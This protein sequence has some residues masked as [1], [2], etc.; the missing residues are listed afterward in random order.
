MQTWWLWTLLSPHWISLTLG[1]FFTLMCALPASKCLQ[2]WTQEFSKND[3]TY[4]ST[5]YQL[6]LWKSKYFCLKQINP[7]PLKTSHSF[8]SQVAH[9]LSA[10]M[11][12]SLK[13]FK[14]YRSSFNKSL[15]QVSRLSTTQRFYTTGNTFQHVSIASL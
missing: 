12:K 1:E 14:C 3:Y 4:L 10:W 15:G 6:L 13:A 5:I 2:D 7:T 9:T 11:M 8:N